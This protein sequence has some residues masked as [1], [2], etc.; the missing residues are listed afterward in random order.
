MLER[1]AAGPVTFRQRDLFPVS[2]GQST[3]DQKG[4]HPRA[5]TSSTSL[6]S[7]PGTGP[8]GLE[9][10]GWHLTIISPAERQGSRCAQRGASGDELPR[11]G[12][13]SYGTGLT[14]PEKHD[15]PHPGQP[16]GLPKDPELSH[17]TRFPQ[18]RP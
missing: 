10:T 6:N 3:E 13:P 16:L 15:H 7:S 17:R 1:A 9:G 14:P 5:T 12:Q 2:W 4:Q 11:N 18:G 8:A